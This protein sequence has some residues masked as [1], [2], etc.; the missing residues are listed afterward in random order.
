MR[1][2]NIKKREMVIAVARD[3]SDRKAYLDTMERQA[4]LDPV[5]GLINRQIFQKHINSFISNDDGAIQ[6]AVA[7]LDIDRFRDINESLGFPIGDQLLRLVA[8][9]FHEY[10]KDHDITIAS[11][12]GDSF[13]VVF[14]VDQHNDIDSHV[15]ALQ[16]FLSRRI[17]TRAGELIMDFTAGIALYPQHATNANDLL[18]RAESAL[19][20]AKTMHSRM[21]LYHSSHKEGL[22]HVKLRVDLEQA[23]HSGEILAHYQP[24]V[25]SLSGEIRLEL[26]ARW[27]HETLGAIKPEVFIS[28]AE[29]T[30]LITQ[31][32]LSL[33]KQAATECAPLIHTGKAKSLSINLSPYSLRDASFPEHV[34]A[35]LANHGL[36]PGHVMLELTEGSILPDSDSTRQVMNNLGSLGFRLA[37]DDF[38]TGHSSLV[39]LKLLPIAELKID[40]SFVINAHNNIDDQ[41]IIRAALSLAKNLNLEVVAEGVE[42]DA[43]IDLLTKLGCDQLQGYVFSRAMPIQQLPAIIDKIHQR[44]QSAAAAR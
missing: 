20:S 22:D 18:H 42:S 39:R 9:R 24:I 38:G 26:L 32:T 19:H 34:T 14:A 7:L 35:I 44:F 11:L 31:L 13:A 33:I 16:Q 5:T 37:V 21:M 17:E 4:T 40:K 15:R 8:N 1:R 12:G 28:L 41:I 36:E 3:I 10:Q 25:H 23:I 27:Q 30:G 2:I 43:T 6:F 29:Y